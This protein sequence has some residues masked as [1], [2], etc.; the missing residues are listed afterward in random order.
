MPK[1]FAL[2]PLRQLSQQ[3]ND[4]ATRQLGLLNRNQLA[5]QNKLEMLQQYRKDYQQKMQQAERDG[6]DL[7]ELCNYRDFIYRLDDAITQQNAV[8]AQAKHSVQQGLAALSD[9][10]RRMKSYDTLAQRH[11]DTEK[12]KEAKIEQAIQD[13]HN[14]R[15]A[16]HGNNGFDVGKHELDHN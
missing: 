12:K 9:A 4:A 13:E 5:A 16:A 3:K 2:Q 6:M 14:E 7:Q 1:A 8:L 15:R 11:L 10:K